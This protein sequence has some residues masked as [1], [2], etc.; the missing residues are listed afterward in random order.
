VPGETQLIE[1]YFLH[2]GAVRTDVPLGV[3][4]DAAVLR[5]QPG[6]EL[7]QTTDSLVPGAHFLAGDAPRSLGHRAL[8]INLSDLAAMGA[9]PAWALLSLTL[10]EADEQ[11]L[12]EF[13]AGFGLLAR[14]QGVALVGGNLT[15][16]PLNISVT[17]TGQVPADGALRRSGAAPGD[18]LWV[19]GTP[20]DAR[21]GLQLR[22]PE[23]AFA[24][25]SAVVTAGVAAN[26]QPAQRAALLARWEYP[27]PR[28]ALGAALRGL[29]SAVIDVSDG[30][31]V[32]LQRLAAASGCAAVIQLA[33][34]PLSAELR[35][36]AGANA[37]RMALAGGEDYELCLA[38]A[39][40]RGEALQAAA[41]VAGTRLTRI[42]RLSAGT[43]LAVQRD[44]AVMQFS[45]VGFD[46][47]AR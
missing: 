24:A 6:H 37:W 47:F 26:L 29:A 10:P 16:G 40:A 1:R 12:G 22:H 8:A 15:R 38:A 13:A 39:P 46:H 43:G 2:L 30:L 3:G 33:D 31:H 41:Q 25:D 36:A 45:H 42:G 23:L 35:A 21:A 32:D 28:V 27:T 11:W 20:G 34:L 9:A 7:V 19:S 4:D 44:G 18:E 17:L 5:P 14:A